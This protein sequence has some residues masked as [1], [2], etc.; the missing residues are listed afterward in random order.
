MIENF[1]REFVKKH[2]QRLSGTVQE[3]EAQKDFKNILKE[4]D[5]PT[6]IQ[7][8]C[9]P[10]NDWYG[11]LIPFSI[12][13]TI[14]LFTSYFFHDI[15]LVISSFISLIFIIHFILRINLLGFLFKNQNSSNL[16]GKINT[17][18]KKT[19]VLLGAHID[20]TYEFRWWY[21][22]GHFGAQLNVIGG[23]FIILMPLIIL[24][25]HNPIFQIPFIIK[26]LLSA[27]II[28]PI[29]TLATIHN[30]KIIINGATDDLS[31]LSIILKILN[32]LKAKDL[33]NIK[34]I[35]II[36]GAEEPGRF[37]S[38]HF[39]KKLNVNKEKM[40][41]INIDGII[42]REDLAVVESDAL[43]FVRYSYPKSII[44]AFMKSAKEKNVLFKTIRIINAGT[45]AT[46]FA[47][48]GINALNIIGSP[49]KKIDPCYH[50]R[51]DTIDR[52]DFKLCEDVANVINDFIL[53]I[54]EQNN[55]S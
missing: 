48:K 13:V 25:L 54:D 34:L 44:D 47:K 49:T 50:T 2:P 19:N 21:L 35:P 43:G 10:L 3:L 36:F 52:V 11:S 17:E 40:F 32:D 29:F 46:N 16:V 30:K 18:D 5:V 26:L 53:K 15:A 31:G 28:F 24:V 7:K 51:L 39:V 8:F 6:E 23:F 41:L 9:A 27:S 1:I 55:I 22:L 37:G 4:I 20:S 33:K 12:S 38:E 42:N 14:S 45:D